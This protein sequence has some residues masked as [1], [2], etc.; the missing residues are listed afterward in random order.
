MESRQWGLLKWEFHLPDFVLLDFGF[1]GNLS[2]EGEGSGSWL[3]PLNPTKEDGES[4]CI[5]RG[6]FQADDVTEEP[7][8]SGTSESDLTLL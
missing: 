7:D 1:H 8:Q 4:L 5:A 6:L 3:Y 2:L